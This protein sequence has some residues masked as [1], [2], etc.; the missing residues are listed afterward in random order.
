M[1]DYSDKVMDHFLKP[2]NV[3]EIENPDAEAEVG[4]LSCGDML[5]LTLRIGEDD[6]IQDAKFKTYGCGSAIAAASALTEMIK[7]KTVGEAAAITNHH[8]ADFLGG[9]P[10]EKMH[11][12]VMGQEALEQA[13]AG[14]RG[15]ESVAHEEA[16]GTIVC[17]CFG[18]TDRTIERVVRENDLHEVDRVT[19]YCKAGGGCESCHGKI[20]EIIHDVWGDEETPV[21]KR[22]A[23]KKLTNI[24]KIRLVQ[25]TIDR[26]IRPSLKAD[27]GDI[28]LVDIEG[29]KVLVAFRGVCAD[30]RISPITARTVVGAKLR[31]FVT[32]SLEVEV[33]NE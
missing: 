4:N 6:R 33:V 27:G 20:E 5:R 22:P 32:D 9:L 23:P 31:E 18:I 26:E 11:C 21:A 2:R 24:E 15:E 30:C 28:E 1:W 12:S 3:G 17:K 29:D 25:E 10:D 14:Y 8:I 16:E 7:G 13:I 19:H